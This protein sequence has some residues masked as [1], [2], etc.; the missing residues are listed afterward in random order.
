[1]PCSRLS[2]EPAGSPGSGA[3]REALTAGSAAP[4]REPHSAP[5]KQT[6]RETTG[7]A[8]LRTLLRE[9]AGEARNR[10]FEVA[11]NPC[12]GAAI[13]AAQGSAE[14]EVLGRGI[15]ERWGGPH[16]EINALAAAGGSPSGDT[17]VVTL[18][19]CSTHGK[20]PPCTEAI[21]AAGIR[22]VVAGARDPDRRHRGRGLELLARAGLE[23]VLLEESAPLDV[24][25]PHFVAWTADERVRRPRPWVIAKWAQTRSGQLV[26]PLGVGGGRWISAPD[27]LREVQTVRSRVDAIVTS[28]QTVRADDPRMTV[29]PPG[30]LSRPPL[31]VVLDTELLTPPEARILRFPESAAEA[32]GR[33]LVLCRAG[34]DA[35][36]HRALV[37]AGAEVEGVRAGPGRHLALR[38]ALDALWARGVRRVL[39]ECGTVLLEAFLES[40]FVDQLLIYTGAVNGG[41]GPSMGRWLEASRLADRLDRECGEDSVLEAFVRPRT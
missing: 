15:H 19:P 26:P 32:A 3:R 27:S 9:L 17:L 23:V 31:R 13:L 12:V 24:I 6:L 18:E 10:R 38:S 40:G 39:L 20:T 8:R 25:A 30:D 41:R 4:E 22:C 36:R 35:G 7:E 11:P 1:M 2:M 34:A 16:A 28:V 5:M 29:R 21:L 33:T 37:A 14:G